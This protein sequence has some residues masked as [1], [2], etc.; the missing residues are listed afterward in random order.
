MAGNGKTREKAS[1]QL[2]EGQRAYEAKRAAKAGVTLERWLEDK[3]RKQA[4]EQLQEPRSAPP[5]TRK[6]GLMTRLLDRAHQPL[7]PRTPKS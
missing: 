2:A 7:K 3:A 5:A 1:R 4:A 6:R